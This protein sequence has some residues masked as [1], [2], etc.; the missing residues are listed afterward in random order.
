MRRARYEYVL[1]T[2]P[3]GHIAMSTSPT[4]IAGAGW[5]HG[6]A[7]APAAPAVVEAPRDR[8]PLS[9]FLAHT[10]Q[11]GARQVE[12]EGEEQKPRDEW[13]ADSGELE[14]ASMLLDRGTV[15]TPGIAALAS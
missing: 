5:T 13:D 9:W 8:R 12:A 7:P 4:T 6:R 15:R 1:E 14:H 3:M 11:I 10:P 2:P